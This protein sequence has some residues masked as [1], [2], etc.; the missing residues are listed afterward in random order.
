MAQPAQ[1]S[2]VGLPQDRRLRQ[3]QAQGRNVGLEPSSIDLE[4]LP[5]HPRA[6]GQA[7]S[8]KCR[9]DAF[10]HDRGQTHDQQPL[11]DD[12]PVETHVY[13]LDSLSSIPA[14]GAIATTWSSAERR[15]TITPCVWRPICEIAPTDVRS[16]IP[17]ALMTRISSSGSLTTRT[18]ASLPTRSVTFNV[19]TPWPARCF[20]GYSPSGV[21]LPYPRCVITSRSPPSTTVAI[22]ATASPLPSLIPMTPCVSRPIARTS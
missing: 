6:T 18:A 17:L 5:N 1:Q 15:M 20:F 9:D 10:D 16:T 8:P 4:S 14:T 11:T 21:R 22:P 7:E 19:N 2:A 13:S 3:R 12:C